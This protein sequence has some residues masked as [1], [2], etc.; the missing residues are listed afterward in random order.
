MAQAHARRGTEQQTPPTS[1]AA[2]LDLSAEVR[3]LAEHINHA[4]QLALIAA[5]GPEPEHGAEY[6]LDTLRELAPRFVALRAR[7]T[8]R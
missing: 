2:A 6:L 8:S 5:D 1:I 7:V 3:A 4:A